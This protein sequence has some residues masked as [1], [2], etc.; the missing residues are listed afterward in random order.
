MVEKISAD[1]MLKEMQQIET[2]LQA[3]EAKDTPGTSGTDEF[4]NVLG[5]LINDVDQAQKAADVSLKKLAT[6]ENTSIQE[7]VLKMEEADVSFRLMKE[8]RDKLLAAYREVM[9]MST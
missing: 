6:G 9:G 7:V 3:T 4:S 2:S 1:M 8:I 5:K